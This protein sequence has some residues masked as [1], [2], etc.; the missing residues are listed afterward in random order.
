MS[1]FLP[2]VPSYQHPATSATEYKITT[3]ATTDPSLSHVSTSENPILHPRKFD[4][5]SDTELYMH[6]NR[7]IPRL[8]FYEP[9][10]E[11]QISRLKMLKEGYFVGHPRTLVFSVAGAVAP[12]K[13][14]ALQTLDLGFGFPSAA[15][16]ASASRDAEE[17]YRAAYSVHFGPK[18]RYNTTGKVK[19][20]GSKVEMQKIAELAAACEA[21]EFVE[22]QCK[23]RVT[24]FEDVSGEIVAGGFVVGVTSSTNLW[25]GITEHIYKWK[26]NDFHNSKGSKV[27]GE[28]LWRRI[29][30]CMNR[31]EFN[32]TRVAWLLCEK[33]DNEAYEAAQK[34]VAEI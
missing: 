31:F 15:A 14:D 19:E 5:E 24:G 30:E 26:R 27:I 13:G 1:D 34:K 32:Q 6:E 21:L 17:K 9:E 25:Y 7:V 8:F 4:L 33:E 16:S 3:P 20:V 22:S 29:D 28:D 2:T 18:S 12:V 11:L 23:M 10:G